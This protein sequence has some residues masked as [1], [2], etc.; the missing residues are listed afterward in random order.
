MVVEGTY[1]WLRYIQ[2]LCM[3]VVDY[4]FYAVVKWAYTCASIGL[5]LDYD[6]HISSW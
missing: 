1:I 3:K 5:W 4:N 6:R 2:Y